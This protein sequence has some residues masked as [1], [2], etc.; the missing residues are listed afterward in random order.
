MYYALIFT[1][2]LAALYLYVSINVT[3]CVRRSYH[4]SHKKRKAQHTVE[5][6]MQ[7]PWTEFQSTV[8]LTFK[9]ITYTD[10]LS[11]YSSYPPP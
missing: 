1:V 11:N 10:L 3:L 9:I 8:P 4:F 7:K 5:L 6:N 2:F